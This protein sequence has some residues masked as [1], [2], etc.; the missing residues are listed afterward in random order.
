M[1]W[2][3]LQY[4]IR[5]EYGQ[6]GVYFIND[7]QKGQVLKAPESPYAEVFLTLLANSFGLNTP[8]VRVIRPDSS[9]YRDVIE[10]LKPYIEE[11][12]ASLR[13]AQE[14]EHQKSEDE[15]D[16][17]LMEKRTLDLESLPLFLLMEDLSGRSLRDV[18]QQDLEDWYGED[19]NLKPTGQKFLADLGKLLV[20]DISIRNIDRFIFWKLPGIGEIESALGNLGNIFIRDETKE[21]IVIDSLMDINIEIVDYANA[22]KEVLAKTLNALPDNLVERGQETLEL[23]GYEI[24]E[25]GRALILQG[26]REG[27]NLLYDL[28]Q[29]E[30]LEQIKQE[31]LRQ[32]SKSEERKV[33]AIFQFI[34][35]IVETLNLEP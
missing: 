15:R 31:S 34:K 10:A 22:V 29:G 8:T 23:T 17:E 19:E 18:T 30:T 14:Q 2:N 16:L 25:N 5:S 28:T 13:V 12:N 3:Q 20:F 27:I 9:E 21:L 26:V 33:D 6:D 4:A 35:K 7:G 11:S 32:L 1:K 24:K